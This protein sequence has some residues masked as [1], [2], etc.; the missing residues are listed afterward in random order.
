MNVYPTPRTPPN[1]I[2]ALMR[3]LAV[4][5]ASAAE[6]CGIQRTNLSSWLNG[7][8]DALSKNN[9]GLLLDWLGING[10]KLKSAQM[11]CWAL[12]NG[13]AD[14]LLVL[15]YFLSK[16]E[17]K[18]L[19]IF[20]SGEETS[21]NTYLRILTKPRPLIIRLEQHASV[22]RIMPV[23]PSGIGYGQLVKCQVD[24]IPPNASYHDVAR[25]LA[26]FYGSHSGIPVE[27]IDALESAFADAPA[28]LELVEILRKVSS[29][30]WSSDRLE[31]LILW[32]V[33][34]GW[35]PTQSYYRQH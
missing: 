29:A 2:A 31:K 1:A 12:R 15:D 24:Q 10:M 35:D 3:L 30:G 32:G 33:E 34:N 4:S 23:I 6:A 27:R 5:R 7:R 9:I 21:R 28:T 8:G 16:E 26:S 13:L 25:A 17:K 14:L 19:Q 18:Y 20:S 22:E 11:H